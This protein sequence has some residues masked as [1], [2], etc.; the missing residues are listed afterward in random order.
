MFNIASV[1]LAFIVLTL[2]INPLGIA[3][4]FV[5]LRAFVAALDLNIGF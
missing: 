2:P 5:V 4:I 3:P 1:P